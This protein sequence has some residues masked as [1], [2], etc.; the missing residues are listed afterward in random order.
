MGEVRD[1][2]VRGGMAARAD[3][4]DVTDLGGDEQLTV[5]PLVEIEAADRPA[6]A[7]QALFRHYHVTTPD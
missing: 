5:E 7:A 1:G 6:C 2:R 4:V 3:I